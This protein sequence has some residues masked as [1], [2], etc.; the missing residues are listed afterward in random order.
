MVDSKSLLANCQRT[1]QLGDTRPFGDHAVALHELGLAV[2][3]CGGEDGKRPLVRGWQT[4]MRS[5]ETIAEWVRQHPDANIGLSCGPS[6]IVI[7]DIDTPELTESMLNRFGDTPLITSTPRGGAHFWYRKDGVIRSGNLKSEGL[8][9]DIKADGGF[10]VMPPSFNRQSGKEYLFV[11]G[12]QDDLAR[13]PPFRREALEAAPSNDS[14]QASAAGS[15]TAGKRNEALH[16][17]LLRA[18]RHV[19]SSNDLLA[20]ARQFNEQRLSPPLPDAEVV[21]TAGSAWKCQSEG[22]NGVG[23]GGYVHWSVEQAQKCA[24]HKRG[25]DA[26]I[27]MTILRAKHVNREVPFAV[28]AS[29]MAEHEVIRGRS[30]HRTRKALE[31]AI[32]LHLIETVR[33]GGAVQ[34]T[35]LST[36]CPA[37]E[38]AHE[39][40]NTPSPRL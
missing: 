33:K 38:I 39:Y 22:R 4:G 23:S 40:N 25:G 6:Q 37:W 20:E 3:P 32:A 13:L 21:K 19:G 16:R 2:L 27:L 12:S 26:I 1:T 29:A 28:A 24:R 36:C 18:V 30:E 34:A 35:L 15:I 8:A 10:V 17:H 14:Y 31:A 5:P 11:R 7:V 9:V